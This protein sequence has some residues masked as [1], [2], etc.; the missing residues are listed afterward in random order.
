MPLIRRSFPSQPFFRV[1]EHHL[2]TLAA[3]G[4]PWRLACRSGAWNP[5]LAEALK[6]TLPGFA[7]LRLLPLTRE[8][9]GEL[10]AE[11]GAG[12]REFTDALV[13]AN[14]GRLAAS[15]MRLR[16]A[17]HHWVPTGELPDSQASRHADIPLGFAL[18]QRQREPC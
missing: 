1:L 17:A 15:P 8:G 3:S 6:E 5:S 4:N 18:D 2:T 16:A 9:A 7:E 10:A 14:L 13:R 11:V 12:P